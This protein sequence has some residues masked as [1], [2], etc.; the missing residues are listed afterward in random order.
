MSEARHADVNSSAGAPRLGTSYGCYSRSGRC[1]TAYPSASC[2]ESELDIHFLRRTRHGR[3]R[4][5]REAVALGENV[6]RH[7][8]QG[9]GTVAVLLGDV[10]IGH[11]RT[12]NDVDGPLT[13]HAEPGRR[14]ER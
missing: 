10:R 3:T 2:F 6:H 1:E 5:E 4:L 7:V 11:R 8:V 14:R 9:H 12:V 13:E